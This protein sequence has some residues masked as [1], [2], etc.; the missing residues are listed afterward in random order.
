MFPEY[1]QLI[2]HLKTTH[3]RF[4]HLFDKHNQLDHEIARMENGDGHGYG[5]EIVRMKKEKLQ[6][7]DEIY[8]IL[9][10]ESTT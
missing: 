1:R 7:K 5:D 6:L 10:E 9:R 4:Q 3:P 8:K 2:S